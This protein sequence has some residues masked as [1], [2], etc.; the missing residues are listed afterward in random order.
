M[1][2]ELKQGNMS[3]AQ[4]EEKFT[5]LPKFDMQAIA[6]QEKRL[7]CFEGIRWKLGKQQPLADIPL[8][9]ILR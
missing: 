4:Y 1:S 5:E 9:L 3:I 6:D 2:R 7:E 8:L